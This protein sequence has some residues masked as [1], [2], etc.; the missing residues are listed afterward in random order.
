MSDFWDNELTQAEIDEANGYYEFMHDVAYAQAQNFECGLCGDTH[1]SSPLYLERTLGWEL[2]SKGHFCRSCSFAVGTPSDRR[3]P[4][5]RC[6]RSYGHSTNFRC[7]CGERLEGI[8]APAA[9]VAWNDG[10]ESLMDS[11]G[12]LLRGVP[13]VR[14]S[15]ES[16]N[17][18]IRAK[19]PDLVL[20]F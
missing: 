2:N 17:A 13:P 7:L 8:P 20:E 10:S 18:R 1:F 14:E 15:A 16:I 6:G 19:F 4:R 9:T 12:M 5:E 3:C 11:W